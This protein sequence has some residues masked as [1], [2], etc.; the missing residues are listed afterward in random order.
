MSEIAVITDTESLSIFKTLTV[1][2]SLVQADEIESTFEKVYNQ[3]YKIIFVTENVYE[4]CRQYI[5]KERH[6]PIVTVL[7]SL[8]YM[9]ELGRQNLSKLTKIATGTEL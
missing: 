5:Q 1:D 8:I 7:P 3:E 6:F 9:K 2:Y 4:K